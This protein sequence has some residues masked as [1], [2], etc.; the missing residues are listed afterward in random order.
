MTPQQEQQLRLQAKAR[1]YDK[2]KEDAYVEFVRNKT[3][4]ASTPPADEK[5]QKGENF[6]KSLAKDAL[7]T[8]VVKPGA[9]IGQAA[10]YG[11]GAITKDEH[12][13]QAAFEDV[14]INLGP[15]GKYN[16]EEQKGGMSGIKQVA[17][18]ATKTAS[19]LYTPAKGA[20]VLRGGLSGAVRQGTIQ[21]AKT[22]AIGG[23]LYS[24]GQALIDDKSAG[25]IVKDTATGA[26]FGGATGGALGGTVPLVSKG[27]QK[28]SQLVKDK[29]GLGTKQ[30]S[31]TVKER[32]ISEVEQK[33]DE[34]FTGTKSAKK[35]YGKSTAQ[36]K[37]PSRFLAE[38]GL[39]VDIDNGKVNAQATIE[40]ITKQ[41]EP[42]EDV[43]DD[44]LKAKDANPGATKISL[45]ELGA[46]AKQR[47]S[48]ET[49]KASGYL[50]KQYKDIDNFIASLKQSFGNS[51]NLSTLNQIKRGQW[52]QSKVFDAT[53][54]SYTKDI[55]YALGKEAKEIIEQSVQEADIKGLNSYLGDHF[56]AINNLMKIDGN[57]IRGGRLGK[58]FARTAGAVIGAKAGPLGSI[59]GALGG[60][61]VSSVMQ[62][63]HIANPIKRMMFERITRENPLYSQA[64]KALRL[65][66][67]E[68]FSRAMNT[69]V[70]PPPSFIPAAPRTYE[71]KP[72]KL[73][74]SERGVGRNP[75]SGR[76]FRYYKSTGK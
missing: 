15:L 22:G 31:N 67:E 24:G 54:P 45:D 52:Q 73:I 46:K 68:N 56:D 48:T 12:L 4:P 36:G 40:K 61:F 17:G 70:L 3:A 33:Y 43:L 16:I 64:Q 34:L 35:T 38:H 37:T 21:G 47:I 7:K 9:R 18:D 2:A 71:S 29:T 53:R 74:E 58:Y 11:L 39:I 30:P 5:K 63:N 13:K 57:A 10:A 66:R 26:A 72:P 25:E 69:K 14:S 62:N 51:V 49:N 32:I 44:I 1:G 75:K 23:G 55:H 41:A 27:V 6:L 20:S 42:L 28:T 76:M 60:D 59:A 65:L 50:D 8:L 19:Y